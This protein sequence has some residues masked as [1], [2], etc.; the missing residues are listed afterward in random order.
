MN[1]QKP[2]EA[3]RQQ[4]DAALLSAASLKTEIE[5]RGFI[6]QQFMLLHK[7]REAKRIDQNEYVKLIDRLAAYQRGKFNDYLD[8]LAGAATLGMLEVVIQGEVPQF[9]PKQ[10]RQRSQAITDMTGVKPSQPDENK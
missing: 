4:L 8:M 1:D 5:Q 9:E 6:N 10:A 2:S 7:A 3:L